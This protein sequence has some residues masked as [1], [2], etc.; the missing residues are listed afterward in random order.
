MEGI[1]CIVNKVNGK[2]Y[3]GRSCN[4]KSRWY[5][6]ILNLNKGNH[7]SKELQEDW[8]TFGECSFEFKVLEEIKV[9]QFLPNNL[10]KYSE[11][12]SSRENYYIDTLNSKYN[13][14]SATKLPNEFK[15]YIE[16]LNNKSITKTQLA[17]NLGISRPT[18]DKYIKKFYLSSHQ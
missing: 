6:H 8:N 16:M 17:S 5:E 3:V 14:N 1:Y 11:L 10:A 18:L 2:V 15:E 12:M 7:Y 4:M 13:C 9:E